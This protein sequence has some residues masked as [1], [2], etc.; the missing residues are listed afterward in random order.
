MPAHRP[1]RRTP[2]WKPPEIRAALDKIRREADERAAASIVTEVIAGG[3]PSFHIPEDVIQLPAHGWKTRPY[4]DKFWKY[5]TGEDGLGDGRKKFAVLNWH[6]RAGKDALLLNLIAALTTRR[7]GMYWHAFPLLNQA[8]RAIWEGFMNSES[9][10]MLDYIPKDLRE[11]SNQQELRI[12]LSTGSTYQLVGG[13]N[14]DKLTGSGPIGIGYSE[15]AQM[16]PA[17]AD[18]VSPMMGENDG[19]EVYI[20]TPRGK[21]HFHNIYEYARTAPGCFAETLTIEDTWYLDGDGNRRPVI[22]QEYL[23]KERKKGKS[24]EFIRQEYYCDWNSAVEG[25]VYALQIAASEAASRVGD[26]PWNP[27]WPVHTAWDLGYRDSTV[28]IFYQID[29]LSDD[30]RIIDFYFN[31][32]KGIGYYCDELRKKPYRYGDHFA[33]WDVTHRTLHSE[34]SVMD[35]ARE[36]GVMFRRILRSGVNDGIEAVRA[37]FPRFRFDKTKCEKLI[38]ALKSY[39]FEFDEDQKQFGTEPVHDWASHRADALRYLAVS[40]PE[41]RSG[42]YALTNLKSAP[43]SPEDTPWEILDIQEPDYA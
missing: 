14:P 12:N 20:S 25:A 35:I 36:K 40:L 31:S 21:N 22:S 32:Q 6:R 42:S 1:A 39:T 28:V 30:V 10:R 7:T 34:N 9:R 19:W 43:R 29:P 13:D 11:D 33:P 37:A 8:R 3:A 38:D 15:Y 24:E 5:M 41:S 23:E 18:F 27:Q 26:V 17:I 2:G 16:N 4:Q